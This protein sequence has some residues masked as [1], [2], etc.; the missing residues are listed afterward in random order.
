MITL[1]D[2]HAHLDS[3]KFADDRKDVLEKARG[4]GVMY[5]LNVSDNVHSCV[6]SLKLAEEESG[7]YASLGVH[8]HEAKSF[9]GES[10]E[11]IESLAGN[12][13]V[14]AV[15]ETGLDYYYE[16]SSREVQNEAF[17]KQI[18][19]AIKVNLPLI[20]HSRDA[21]RETLQALTEMRAEEVGGV[22]HCFSGD[23]QAA[24]EALKL[25]FY[26]SLGGPV[27]FKNAK[28]TQ[29]VAE[30]VPEEKLLIETDCPYLSPEPK[31]GRR[32]EPAHVF[33]IAQ[34]IAEIR[35]ESL[36][37][38]AEYTTSNTKRLFRIEN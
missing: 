33:F 3:K 14:V 17:R 5:I 29:Q 6:Q 19:L 27:T 20:V 30:M 9:T 7:V 28:K 37:K 1:F 25:G 21:H 18:E 35:G 36:E 23:V 11:L 8:P 31:R 12:D 32:N 4:S 2:S 10:Y 16:H 38:V 26:I 15:G 34:K 24:R 13:K 22:M